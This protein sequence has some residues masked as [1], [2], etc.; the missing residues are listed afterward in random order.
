MKRF[1]NEGRSEKEARAWLA[2]AD[3]ANAHVKVIEA[4]A[5]SEAASS[6]I[7]ATSQA[8]ST[9]ESK[10]REAYVAVEWSR[11]GNAAQ[12]AAAADA[13]KVARAEVAVAKQEAARAI[14]VHLVSQRQA[15][16]TRTHH[17]DLLSGESSISQ[18]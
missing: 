2:Y 18:V 8:V 7:A 3:E 1:L 4:N 16:A 5:V 6:R 15:R 17:P 10:A 14:T 12:R 11:S 9:A 13:A